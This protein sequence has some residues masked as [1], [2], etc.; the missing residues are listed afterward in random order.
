MTR[1]QGVQRSPVACQAAG[2]NNDR[3]AC[4]RSQV[5]NSWNPY[6][7]E[8]GYFRIK[9]GTNECNIEDQVV[10]SGPGATWGKFTP[11]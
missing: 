9:R 4:A 3:L 6:W 10:A 11:K 8:E 2:S 7:G 5:A 1:H